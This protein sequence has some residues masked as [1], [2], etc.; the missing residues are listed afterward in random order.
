M[1]IRTALIVD[2]CE[3]VRLALEEAMAPDFRVL[4]C[5]DGQTALELL[6]TGQPEVLILELSLPRLDG[7]GLLRR[8]AD[9]DSPPQVL[10]NTNTRTDYVL[11]AL[12][13]LP[14]AYAMRKP[15]DPR[16]VA[17]RARELLEPR[18]VDPVAWEISDILLRLSIPNPSQGHRHMMTGLPMLADRP[19][20]FLGKTFYAE[21]A[22]R[23]CATCNSVEKAIRDAIHGGWE[24]GDRNMWLRYFPGI[25]RC[26]QNKQF[27]TRIASLLQ[28]QRKCG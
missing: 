6:E 5:G 10:V 9:W 13:D 14:V 12:Q 15:T 17:E 22:R 3:E 8:I 23:N 4:C 21:I 18:C 16:I 27:L 20:Q 25:S 28:R 26:P 19:D 1:Q 24:Q 2:P 11:A 7:I